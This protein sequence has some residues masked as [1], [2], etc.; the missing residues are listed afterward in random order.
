MSAQGP[1]RGAAVVVVDLGFGDAGKGLATDFLVRRTG[2]RLV[3]RY[4]GGAQAGHNVVAPDGR[5]HTF[6]QLGSGTFVPG[7][8]TFLARGVVVHPTALLVEAKRLAGLGVG[9]ALDRLAISERARIITPFHQAAGRLRELA[10]GRE[11]HGTCG[12]GV[13]EAVADALARPDE[14]LRAGNLRRGRALLEPLRR[15][16]ERKRAE[17]QEALRAAKGDPAAEGERRL[18]EDPEVSERWLEALAPLVAA[19]VVAEDGTL[20]RELAASGGAVFEGA[21]GVLLDEAHGFHPHTTWSPCTPEPA[22][23]LLREAKWGG[24]VLRLGVLRSYAHRHGPGPLP[25]EDASLEEQL[26]EP[27]NGKE[28]WQGPFRVGWP[29]LVLA[30]YAVRA[31]QGVDA[32]GLTHLDACNRVEHWRVCRAYRAEGGSIADLPVGRPPNLWHQSS[33]TAA[34]SSAEPIY[35][36]EPWRPDDVAAALEAELGAPVAL[37]ARGPT[38]HDVRWLSTGRPSSPDAP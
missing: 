6:A 19:K 27:H 3:V 26:P 1:P 5:H 8:R 35:G 10:R 2:A 11:R 23:A 32:L 25:T 24:G 7:V 21:Q 14:A 22:L 28:G 30:R 37:A 9:D 16:Q 17:L 38:S 15:L 33:L 13:G 4:N 34:L 20:T 29:D 18:L 12:V 36:D 31:A